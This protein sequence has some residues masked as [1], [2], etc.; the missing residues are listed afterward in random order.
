MA[1]LNVVC[2][3]SIISIYLIFILER[4]NEAVIG[5]EAEPVLS[6]KNILFLFLTALLIISRCIGLGKIPGGFNQDGAM[7]AVDA[8]ALANYG[9]DRFGTWLPAHFT[10]WGYGQMSVLLSYLTVPFIKLWGLSPLTARL[11]MV[12]VSTAGGIALYGLVKEMYSRKAAFVTLLFLIINPWHFMQSRWALDC[13]VFPHMFMIGLYFLNHGIRKKKYMYV[14]MVFFALCM[15]SYGVSFYMVPVF[16]LT[17]CILFLRK[18]IAAGKQALIMA[19]VY[20]GISF[21]IYGTMLINFMKWDTLRL[22]FVTMTYFE[23]SVRSGDILFFSEHL[24]RQLLSNFSSLVKV[25]FL[26]KPDLIWNA[27]DDFG[28]MYQCSMPFILAGL[29]IT[30]YK[31]KKEDHK[32][33]KM[34]YALLLA[35]WCSSIFAGLC[36]NYVNVNRMN[37]IFYSHIIFAGIA[38]YE[39]IR[40]W[41]KIAPLLLLI[42]GMQSALFFYSYFTDWADRMKE[43]FYEDFLEAV[44][45]AGELGCDYYYITPDTQYEGAAN[46]SEILTMFAQQIDAEYFQGKTDQF[47]GAPISY[48]DRY[49]YANPSKEEINSHRFTAY[50]VKSDRL[51]EFSADEFSLTEFGDYCVLVPRQ[52]AGQ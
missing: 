47:K 18:R 14:S 1:A 15:Y 17:V 38:V 35:Y 27:M 42:Y 19:A 48:R 20:F 36:I 24:I 43:V 26:Q 37:I 41:K 52:Y 34:S 10:A 21:P 25:V 2:V 39:L 28:T 23:G 16:L 9:T 3:F 32:V 7:G 46:V 51:G 8:L 33:R 49:H 31:V 4:K 13:N 29:G 6:V 44:S 50:V 45:Y 11:P 40:K 22:P 5:Q 12:I 30:I